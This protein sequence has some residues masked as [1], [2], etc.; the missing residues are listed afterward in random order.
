MAHDESD[1]GLSS[2]SGDAAAE[3]AVGIIMYCRS[4][5]PDCMRA[6][7]WLNQRGIPY[8]EVD[9]EKNPEGL[10]RAK[11]LNQGAL[12]TPTFELGDEICVDF[13]PD[14]LEDMIGID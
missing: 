14:R 7:A 10:Q 11:D 4:W 3:E 1:E 9:V 6:K 8:V 5:C 12:H 2:G 13:R